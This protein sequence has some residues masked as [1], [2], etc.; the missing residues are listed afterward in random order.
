MP[1]VRQKAGK[2]VFHEERLFLKAKQRPST[3]PRFPF[4]GFKNLHKQTED[5]E[6][7][8]AFERKN[9]KLPPTCPFLL[10][11]NLVYFGPG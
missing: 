6:L 2:S 9:G 10:T 11:I 4:K 8:H 5:I 1:I 7:A 3:T